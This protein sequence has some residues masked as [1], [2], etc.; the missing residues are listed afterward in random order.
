MEYKLLEESLFLN[1]GLF[2]KKKDPNKNYLTDSD[3]KPLFDDGMNILV[4]SVS[5]VKK[6]LGKSIHMTT[7]K[8]SFKVNKRVV[9]YPIGVIDANTSETRKIVRDVAKNYKSKN[10]LFG[11]VSVENLGSQNAHSSGIMLVIKIKK[12]KDYYY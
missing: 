8:E 6:E 7:F 11:G 9:Q 3:L 4:Q 10:K 1:E 5:R 12:G 2:K